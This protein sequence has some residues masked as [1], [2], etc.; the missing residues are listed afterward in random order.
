[1]NAISPGAATAREHS[2]EDGSGRFG[3]QP[4]PAPPAVAALSPSDT[5]NVTVDGVEVV[6]GR[7]GSGKWRHSLS[8]A[9]LAGESDL[10][11][12][13]DAVAYLLDREWFAPEEAQ[14]ALDAAR[15]WS[16]PPEDVQEVALEAPPDRD[17][18]MWLAALAGVTRVPGMRAP[19]AMVRWTLSGFLYRDP[20]PLETL[21]PEFWAQAEEVL[22]DADPRGCEHLDTAEW[23]EADRNVVA[24][25]FW[26]Q[27]RSRAHGWVWCP[28]RRCLVDPETGEPAS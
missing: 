15:E 26:A 18:R 20:K 2:R 14:A 4:V 11:D 23:D 3:I 28:E 25:A 6:F 12:S 1:M 27:L 10:A 8:A 9:R 7:N 5:V 21:D 17:P 22:R 13:C 19:G 24:Y 16:G